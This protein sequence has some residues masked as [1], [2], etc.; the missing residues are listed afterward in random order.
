MNG[1]FYIQ[2]IF[3]QRYWKS[4]EHLIDLAT[5]IPA[6][7]EDDVEDSHTSWVVWLKKDENYVFENNKGYCVTKKN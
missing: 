2:Q 7:P 3:S 5:L 6:F 1:T 4:K